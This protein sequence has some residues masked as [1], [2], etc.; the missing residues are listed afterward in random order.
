MTAV[1]IEDQDLYPELQERTEPRG[2]EIV[3]VDEKY[4]EVAGPKDRAHEVQ[5][6][7]CGTLGEPA[8]PWLLLQG[9]VAVPTCLQA[10]RQ[11]KCLM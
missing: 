7:R 6:S 5:G 4:D 8:T 3:Y 2:G 9:A 1:A 11:E 10:A